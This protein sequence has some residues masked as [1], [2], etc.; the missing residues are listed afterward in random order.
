MQ[1][2]IAVWPASFQSSRE[3]DPRVWRL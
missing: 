3:H 2:T 1:L